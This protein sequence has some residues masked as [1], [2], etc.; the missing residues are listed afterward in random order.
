MRAIVREHFGGPE[1]LVIKELPE[2]E[3][4]PG[5]VIIQVKAFGV[6]HAELHMRRGE[7]A[8]ADEI[9]GIECVGIVSPPRRGVCGRQQSGCVYGW[10]RKNHPRQLRRIFR[11]RVASVASIES[12]L[13]WEE[14][15]VIPSLTRL[16]GRA[17]SATWN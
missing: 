10:F 15:A 6:N 1:V 14:L 17:F 4:Q 3:P 7:W 5:H 16:P 8:E 11:A 12:D 13:P 9:S 2:P